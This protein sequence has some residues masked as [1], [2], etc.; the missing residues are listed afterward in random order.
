MEAHVYYVIQVIIKQAIQLVPHVKVRYLIV[1]N[2]QVMQIFQPNAQNVNQEIIL[3]HLQ[4]VNHVKQ[5][6]I[7]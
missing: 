7:V 6:Q 3:Q 5:L 1:L 2:A 4:V